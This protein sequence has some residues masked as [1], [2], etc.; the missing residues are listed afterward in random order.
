MGP[1]QYGYASTVEEMIERMTYDILYIENI[2]LLLDMKI[3]I[4]T[5]LVMIE[6]RGK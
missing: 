6:G 1:S 3:I 5:V 4:Y 2:S